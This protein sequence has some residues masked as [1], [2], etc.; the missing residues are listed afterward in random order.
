MHTQTIGWRNGGQVGTERVREPVILDNSFCEQT[1]MEGRITSC[2]EQ[3]G[4]S[5]VG[6]AAFVE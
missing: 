3:A 2:W 6:L 5:S 1:L 4:N